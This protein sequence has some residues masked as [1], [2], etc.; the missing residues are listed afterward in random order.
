MDRT[1]QQTK[2]QICA[3]CRIPFLASLCTERRTR[4]KP[5]L[6]LAYRSGEKISNYQNLS[7]CKVDP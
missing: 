5:Q 1:A 3:L 6:A 2:A 7:S 4:Y